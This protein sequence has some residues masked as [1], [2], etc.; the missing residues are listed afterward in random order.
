MYN[1]QRAYSITTRI[2]TLSTSSILFIFAFLKEHIPLQQGLRPFSLHKSQHIH[3]YLKEHIPLQQGLRLSP[4]SI[5]LG[6]SSHLK[7]HIP[8]QQGL[9]LLEKTQTAER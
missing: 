2:K 1:A 6:K 3:L 8:L 5:Y 7:E 9:R 4:F